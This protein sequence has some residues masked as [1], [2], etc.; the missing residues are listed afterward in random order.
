[1]PLLLENRQMQTMAS[2]QLVRVL[3]SVMLVATTKRGELRE[4]LLCTILFV[5]LLR[6]FNY[7]IY[8]PSKRLEAKSLVA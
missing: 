7:R 3:A 1:M 8:D 6:P 4:F 5:Q 2:S